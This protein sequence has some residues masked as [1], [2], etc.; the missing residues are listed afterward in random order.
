MKEQAAIIARQM[1][2]GEA[3]V[4]LSLPCFVKTGTNVSLFKKYRDNPLY[5]CVDTDANFRGDH[6]RVSLTPLGVAVIEQVRV[7]LRRAAIPEKKQ[8]KRS[9]RRTSAYA[10]DL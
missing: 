1:T 6:M 7:L 9:T 2:V 4:M 5:R 8:R 3:R 10:S